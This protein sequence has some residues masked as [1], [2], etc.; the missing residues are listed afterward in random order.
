M[1]EFVDGLLDEIVRKCNLCANCIRGCPTFRS[2]SLGDTD[3]VDLQTKRIAFVRDH[4][5]DKD[6][7]TFSK[8]CS[9]CGSCKKM[10]PVGVDP[11]YLNLFCAYS[12][13]KMDRSVYLDF[14]KRNRKM[15]DL[16]QYSYNNAQVMRSVQKRPS[17]IPWMS[18][19]P[20]TPNQKNVVWVTGCYSAKQC[21]EGLTSY[22][23]LQY[24]VPNGDFAAIG[25]MEYCCGLPNLRVGDLEGAETDGRRF[26][27]D[28]KKFRPNKVVT[29]CV[30]C[31][32]MYK[33]AYPWLNISF[34]PQHYSQFLADNLS[35]LKPLFRNRVDMAVTIQDPCRFGRQCEDPYAFEAPRRVLREIAGLELVE[36]KHNREDALCCGDMT[37]F[38]GGEPGVYE[39]IAMMRVEE[40]KE[41]GAEAIVTLCGGC[42]AS[43]LHQTSSHK[44]QVI[45]FGILVGKAIGIEHEDKI[46][47]YKSYKPDIERVLTEAN[48]C[49]NASPYTTDEMRKVLPMILGWQEMRYMGNMLQ[50]VHWKEGEREA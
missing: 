24:I 46:A 36:M 50:H 40:A 13:R 16:P 23:I 30:A 1:R 38:Q 14:I 48:E 49:I 28:A 29:G 37:R 35:K 45:D 15:W 5:F 7:M 22:N 43:F 44:M 20:E 17:E 25:D 10:C 41:T 8:N 9:N 3:P 33:R 34:M 4:V 21:N 19:V 2:S 32:W 26:V 42:M 31:L 12:A 39:A 27:D 18:K 47:K 6:V 11:F